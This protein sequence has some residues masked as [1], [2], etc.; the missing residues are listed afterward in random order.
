MVRF[1]LAALQ[2]AGAD[3]RALARHAGLPVWA[4]GDNGARVS[5]AQLARLWQLSLAEL[6][7]PH[8]G[9]RLGCQWRPGRLHL[10]DYL[11]DTATTLGDALA[12]GHR[13]IGIINS[14]GP[15]ETGLLEE[16]ARVTIFHQPFRTLDPDVH[17]AMSQFALSVSLHRAR[18]TLGREITALHVGLA[19]AAPASHGE[20]AETFGTRSI[21]FGEERTTITFSRSHL[22][23][24]MP[25]ADPRLAAVLRQHAQAVIATPVSTPQWIDRF[26]QVLAARLADQTMS[27]PAVARGLGMSPRTLQ[28]RLERDGTGWREEADTL[29]R[30]HA[31]QL[32][33]AG[34]PR[35]AIAERLGYSDAR[36][37][38]RA[39]HRWDTRSAYRDR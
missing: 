37:L 2:E 17:A 26:R 29:R 15:S 7:V 21:D 18:Q 14:A 10:Y 25:Y 16:D 19:T 3:S 31:I 35:T 23:L 30:D 12:V 4:L 9:S 33:R 36:A 34:M 8:L 6:A 24:P 20:L 39:V 1:V 28:R 27:L 11:F 22:G 13:Y 5:R 32:L 38:R